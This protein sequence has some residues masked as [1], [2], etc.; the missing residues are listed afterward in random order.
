M[1][2]KNVLLTLFL[3]FFSFAVSA[4][5][6]VD[7]LYDQ[8][9]NRISRTLT[10]VALK[11]ASV[12]DSL[13]LDDKT[14]EEQEGKIIKI[15]PNPVRS[16]LTIQITGYDESLKRSFMVY[17][18][19]GDKVMHETNISSEKSI[20]MSNLNDGVYILNI[21]I[22]KDLFQYKIIKSN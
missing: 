2:N 17:N 19:A 3:T 1:I 15:F 12:Q 16:S 18:L 6:R 9:G 14:N 22:G 5:N 7:Y 11:S 4:Q 10:V 21:T 13:N 20:E 8:N